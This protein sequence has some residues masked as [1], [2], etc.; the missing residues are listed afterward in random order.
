[1]N[2]EQIQDDLS[3]YL[4]GE[5][6]PTRKAEIEAHVTGCAACQKRVVEL[7]KLAAGVS[8]MSGM[9]P[10]PQFLS[11]VR[12]K[13]RTEPARRTSWADV[14]FRPY[15][16]KIPVEALALIVVAGTV[17]VLVHPHRAER[18]SETVAFKS[19]RVV[20][21]YESSESAAAAAPPAPPAVNAPTPLADDKF[22]KAQSFELRR[23]AQDVEERTDK[24][25]R[26]GTAKLGIATG[27]GVSEAGSLKLKAG[28]EV[29]A[30]AAKAFPA[31]SRPHDA[32]TLEMKPPV[33]ERQFMSNEEKKR[34]STLVVSN[35][36]GRYYLPND[37]ASD[38]ITI[39]AEDV[40][41]VQTRAEALAK[42][43]GGELAQVARAVLPTGVVGQYESFNGSHVRL[44]G[45]KLYVVVPAEFVGQFK[46]Q[47]QEAERL[48]KE[49][50]AVTKPPASSP[51]TTGV[52]SF[53]RIEGVPASTPRSDAMTVIEIRVVL[54]GK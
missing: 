2:C 40:A 20:N 34:E 43:F 8:A 38:V 16:L 48:T 13:L 44:A 24:D 6:S 23:G 28:D 46:S 4:D 19:A 31:E 26:T 9:R 18:P 17:L 14:L 7:E 30:Q 50:L 1:M 32:L 3:A 22:N 45:Q 10:A 33:V 12:R 51:V 11:D 36:S 52:R 49:R 39:E 5:L 42:N 29:V 21:A 35:A 53:G 54:P 25:S 27:S 15:W 37:R 41:G 47:F